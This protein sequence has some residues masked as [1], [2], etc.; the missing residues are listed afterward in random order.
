MELQPLEIADLDDYYAEVFPMSFRGDKMHPALAARDI[1]EVN[2]HDELGDVAS[3]QPCQNNDEHQELSCALVDF[4]YLTLIIK[5]FYTV[6][7]GE[8]YLYIS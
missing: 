6:D 1:A 3:I 7:A 4:V 2:A 5:D 8:C